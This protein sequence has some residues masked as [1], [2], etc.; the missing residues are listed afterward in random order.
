MSDQ[1]SADL[2]S[3]RIARDAPPP[4]RRF[5]PYVAAAAGLAVVAVAVRALAI[6]YAEARLFKPEVAVTEVG[7]VSPAQAS[8][9][10][11]AT[12][13]VIPQVVAKVG[14]KV[15]GRISKA[16]IREGDAV[17]AGQEIFLLDPSDQK[18]AVASAQARAAAARARVA[19]ARARAR[20]ARANLEETRIQFERRKKLAASGAETQA[21]ADDLGA[22]MKSLEEQVIAADVEAQAADADAGAAQ[23]EVA[24]L[25]V[26]LGNMTITAPIDGT[27]VSKPAAV[28]DVVVPAST[29]VELADFSTL[30]VEVDVPEA[31][32]GLVKKGAPCE[33]SLDAFPE[34]RLRGEV[35]EVSP[36]LNRAKASGTVKVRILDAAVGVLPEMAARVSLLQKPLDAE[37]L[38]VPPKKVIPA[39][40]VAERGGVKVAFVLEEGKVRMVPLALGPTFAGGFELR[41]GPAP[42]ARVIKDPPATLADG[43]AVKEKGGDK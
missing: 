29:L 15:P 28:G 41:E 38:K 12:G 20:V 19:A 33:V 10:L 11:T 16:S 36:R 3:L 43:Q 14:A 42:G 13:Y 24:A 18:S 4:P 23:A 7:M 35:V 25:T 40:A 37:A 9:D 5:W 27:A 26:T 21:N 17:K 30:L 31:R 22:R 39:T 1:L 34:R 6:P 8:V 32:M 2:A